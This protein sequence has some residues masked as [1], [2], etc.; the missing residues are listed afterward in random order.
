MSRY[1]FYINMTRDV[2]PP[3]P[4][5]FQGLIWQSTGHSFSL[6]A[7]SRS[8]SAGHGCPPANRRAGFAHVGADS[9]IRMNEYTRKID[10]MEPENGWFPSSESP[11]P[12]VLGFQV[13]EVNFRGFH[14]K[15]E[16]SDRSV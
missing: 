12:K 8:R 2:K 13:S 7:I 9:V 11:L 1:T 15:S 14:L 3:S 5:S 4:A 6:Q 10:G 16:E